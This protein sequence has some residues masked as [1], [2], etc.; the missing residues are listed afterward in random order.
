MKAIKNPCSDCPFRLKSMPGW[1]GPYEVVEQIVGKIDVGIKFECHTH[2]NAIND[3]NGGR[4]ADYPDAAEAANHCAGALAFMNNTCRLSRNREIAKLQD[5]VGERTD[6]FADQ[7][8]MIAHHT[9]LI[10]LRQ[11]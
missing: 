4:S 3:K 8:Q 10:R 1:L 7:Q 6:V 11:I 2:A 5:K 9:K